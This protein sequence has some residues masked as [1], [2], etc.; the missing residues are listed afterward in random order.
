MAI[1]GTLSDSDIVKMSKAVVELDI[2]GVDTWVAVE[3]WGNT[4]T[5]TRGTAPI[6]EMTT[7]DEVNHVSA[8][9]K[10]SSRVGLV[11]VFTSESTDPFVNLYGQVGSVVDVRCSP[12]GTAGEQ[13]FYTSQGYLTNCTPP[14]W[15]SGDGS[16]AKFE[17]EIAAADILNE[18]ISA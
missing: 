3:S 17:I 9:T 16:P 10:S 8:G 4:V 2:G 7:L 13:R 14:G 11:F 12:T 1:S 15:D 6:G 18:V 5:M